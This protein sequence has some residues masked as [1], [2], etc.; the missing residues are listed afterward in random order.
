MKKPA[1]PNKGELLRLFDFD[2]VRG[3][4]HHKDGGDATYQQG[5][6]YL[7][8]CIRGYG[9]LAHRIIWCAAHAEEP[10]RKIDHINCV[11]HDNR[12]L[13]L[14]LAD[15]QQNVGNKKVNRNSQSR[16]KG[17]NY[18]RKRDKWRARIKGITLGRFETKELAAAAYKAAAIEHFGEYAHA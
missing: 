5:S 14:R 8:V 4:I 3:L 9:F 17:V 16:I 13:N 11:R 7:Y 1:F 15:N 6:G 18:D 10:P 12:L 2:F